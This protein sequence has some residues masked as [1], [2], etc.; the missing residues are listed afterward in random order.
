MDQ[1][2]NGIVKSKKDLKSAVLNVIRIK[3][4]GQIIMTGKAS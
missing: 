3:M 1:E 4:K 2:I